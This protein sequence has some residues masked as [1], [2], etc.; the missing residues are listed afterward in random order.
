MLRPVCPDVVVYVCANCLPAGFALPRQWKHHDSRVVVHE[1]PCTGKIDVQYLM[2]A[3]EGGAGGLCV[4]GCPKG[5]CHLAQGNYRAEVRIR[6]VRQLL[7]EV[8]VEAERVVLLH[9]G[10]Q[11]PAEGAKETIFAAAG[12][13]CELGSSPLCAAK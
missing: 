12:Q 3:L 9:C 5:E 13:L 8:G 2:H 1:M 4:V 6:T 7:S 11:D 10:P